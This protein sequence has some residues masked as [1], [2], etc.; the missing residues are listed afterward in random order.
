[1]LDKTILVTGSTDGIGKQ[2][3]LDLARM[4]ARVLIHGRDPEKVRLT[5]EEIAG[6]TGNE[7]LAVYVADFA[8]LAQVREMAARVL[9]E[10]PRLD[11]L[12][13]NAGIF[14]PHRRLTAD[15]VELTLQVN[16]LAPFLL[17]N[18]LLDLLKRS[19]PSRIVNVASGVHAGAELEWDNLQGQRH[20]DG[21]GAYATSKLCD[22]LFTF[23]LAE[24]LK[25]TGVAANCFGPGAIRTKLLGAGWGRAFGEPPE[26]GAQQAVYLATSPEVEGI[27]G[28]YFEANRPVAPSPLAEDEQARR[29]LWDLSAQ[30]V[31]LTRAKKSAA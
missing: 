11:V 17:T 7:N 27:S 15:G 26:V 23:A 24:R 1:M 12:V 3:A 13:N 30:L 25:G 20:Y 5:Y 16:Y 18:L 22:V 2:T 28:R 6:R 4:G 31:G 19:A 8:S 10:Q 29:H 21:W 9:A 14:E